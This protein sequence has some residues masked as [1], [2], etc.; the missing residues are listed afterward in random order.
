ME[1]E[2]IFKI[3]ILILAIVHAVLS[4]LSYTDNYISE[5]EDAIISTSTFELLSTLVCVLIAILAGILIWD[6]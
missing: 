6:N 5:K 3:S 1:S 4:I 2:T